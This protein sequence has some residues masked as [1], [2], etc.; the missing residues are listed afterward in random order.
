MVGWGMDSLLISSTLG[1]AQVAIF[2]IVQR[3]F[4]LAIQP[5][6]I[7]N[8]P[9]WGAYADAHSRNDRAFIK[10]TLA[11]SLASTFIF[12]LFVAI[13][14]LIF[15][16]WLI[17]KWS[18]SNIVAPITFVAT[19]ALWSV[20]QSFGNAFAIFLNGAGIIRQQV[21]SVILFVILAFPMKIIMI[22]YFDLFGI[23]LATVVAY[24]VSHVF[25]YYFLYLEDIKKNLQ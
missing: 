17:E 3:L 12:A 20:I 10:K 11:R 8:A 25:T 16:S 24:L 15:H 1:V 14:I 4:Q 23:M 6:S 22:R 7:L 2:S 21:V 18:I 13:I 9:L 19:Y 5:L